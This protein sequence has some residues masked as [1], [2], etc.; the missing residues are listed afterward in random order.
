MNEAEEIARQALV[1]LAQEMIKNE[2]SFFEG[3]PRVIELEHLVG[4]VQDR[5]EDFNA[6][7]A[8]VS[9]TDHLPFQSERHLWSKAALARLKPE[10]ERTEQWASEFATK[11]CKNL[12][13]RF[14]ENS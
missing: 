14:D 3:A 13:E 7:T 11:A 5:D 12:I 8:I 1:I 2:V 4:G 9:E 10:Y 6:F